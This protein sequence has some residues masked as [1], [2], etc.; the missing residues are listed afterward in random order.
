MIYAMIYN[1]TIFKI[2]IVKIAR[3]Y[4]TLDFMQSQ[5]N[6]KTT[7]MCYTIKKT[8]NK[9]ILINLLLNKDI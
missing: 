8:F 7:I 3:N 1:L 6:A 5:N 4:M 9:L 2:L